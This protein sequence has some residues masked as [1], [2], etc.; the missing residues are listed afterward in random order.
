MKTGPVK[1]SLNERGVELVLN[2]L[3]TLIEV[4]YEF[5]SLVLWGTHRSASS[6]T[7]TK[8]HQFFKS[9]SL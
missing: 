8:F 6:E 7:F 3:E 5:Y 9:W 1:I 2:W 4:F